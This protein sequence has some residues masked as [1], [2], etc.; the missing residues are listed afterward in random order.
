ML[1]HGAPGSAVHVQRWLLWRWQKEPGAQQ[2]AE[3]A[4]H[5]AS[6]PHAAVPPQAWPA[7]IFLGPVHD[8]RAAEG[9]HSHLERSRL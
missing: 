4:M 5:M 9:W 3:E 1:N 2:P 6:A 8:S 7:G